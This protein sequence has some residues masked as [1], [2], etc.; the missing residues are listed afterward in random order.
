MS[1]LPSISMKTAA[2]LP[3]YRLVT[4]ATGTADTV[5]LPVAV[6]EVLIG[7]TQDTNLNIGDSVPVATGGISKLYFNDTMTSGK[8]VAAS[9]TVPGAGVAHAD[10]T[11]GSYVIGVLIGPAVTATATVADVLI[12]PMFKSI[13]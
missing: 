5:K 12:Q 2:T 8:F 9:T 6:S 1:H 10:V 11:V 4:M 3:A 13:P 7:I